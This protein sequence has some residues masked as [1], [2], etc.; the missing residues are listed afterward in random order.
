[1]QEHSDLDLIKEM[2]RRGYVVRHQ[3]ESTRALS[4]NEVNSDP[5][6]FRSR[7]LEKIRE[8]ISINYLEF[9]ERHESFGDKTIR[10]A[11]LRVL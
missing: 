5:E 10:S 9:S 1:M 11:T 2:R 7:A 3:S 8:Q 6:A 4:W